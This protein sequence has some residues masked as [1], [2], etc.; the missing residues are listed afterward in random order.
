MEMTFSVG[1]LASLVQTVLSFATLGVG[2]VTLVILFRY[3]RDT[4]ALAKTAVEQ[5]EQ[6][7][8]PYLTLHGQWTPGS[9]SYPF[10]INHGKGP[11]TNVRATYWKYKSEGQYDLH[12][13]PLPDFAVGRE[14]MLELRFNDRKP[15]V[16]TYTSLSGQPYETRIEIT[17]LLRPAT[18]HFRQ[19]P[20]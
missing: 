2:I 18:T 3:A 11:A 5:V 14:Q 16:L 19:L 12:E 6:G 13:L 20:R 17:R 4:S 8:I 1:D 9:H 15:I 7:Y 10:V